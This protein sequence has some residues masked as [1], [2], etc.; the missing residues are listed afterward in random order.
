MRTGIIDC[1]TN[2]FNLIIVDIKEN[3]DFSIIHKKKLPVKLG[4][5]GINNKTI[6]KEPFQR[7]LNALKEHRQTIQEFNADKTF[8]FATSAIRSAN[9]GKEF[10][11]AAKKETGIEIKIITGHHEAELIYRGVKKAVGF[12]ENNTLVMDVGGGSTEFIIADNKEVKWKYSFNIGVARIIDQFNP[13]NPIKNEEVE[14]IKNYLEKNLEPL[15]EAVK[16]YPV[17]NLVGC[18][19]SFETLASM[20][21][22]KNHDHDLPSS[23]TSYEFMHKDF[24][25]I[26]KTLLNSTEEERYE[27]KGLPASRVDSIVSAAIYID[28]ISKKLNITRLI[29]SLYAIKEGVIDS[30]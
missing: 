14:A 18:S 7:G 10:A 28:F 29:L 25:N 21:L 1:G 4:Q 16:K 27:M 20:I 11:E 9:N 12:N 30:L 6:Q 2:T 17:K 8:A 26:Y 23:I 13:S 5:G 19:G 15:F 24:I 3:K 22:Y